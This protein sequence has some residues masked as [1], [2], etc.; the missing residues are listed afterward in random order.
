[1]CSLCTLLKQGTESNVYILFSQYEGIKFWW[2]S[3]DE[4]ALLLSSLSLGKRNIYTES[5]AKNEK[6]I[7]MI[8]MVAGLKH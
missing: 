7:L 6:A 3:K 4:E 8:K 2:K 5:I 1:M